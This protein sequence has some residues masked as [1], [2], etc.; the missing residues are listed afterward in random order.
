MLPRYERTKDGYYRP[1]PD[2][3]PT[4]QKPVAEEPKPVEPVP[5]PEP[6]E[7]PKKKQWGR[8]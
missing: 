6:T 5:D 1:V 4:E 8:K 2:S 7:Q 3:E